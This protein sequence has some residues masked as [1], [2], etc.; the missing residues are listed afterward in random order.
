[1]RTLPGVESRVLKT[2][3]FNSQ[4]WLRTKL[5]ETLQQG[6]ALRAIIKLPVV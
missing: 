3:C 4:K 2:P 5:D 6:K 1:M